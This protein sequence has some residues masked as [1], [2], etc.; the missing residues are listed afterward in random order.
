MGTAGRTFAVVVGIGALALAASCTRSPTVV[1][2]PASPG[3]RPKGGNS[4][5]PAWPEVA[6]G[7]KLTLTW[8]IYA[9]HPDPAYPDDGLR[10]RHIVELVAQVGGVAR[11]LRLPPQAGGFFE[12]DQSLCHPEMLGPG[13]VSS[14]GFYL[15]GVAG[16]FV[17]RGP[18]DTLT[19]HGFV[20]TDGLC[21]DPAGNTI[22]CPRPTKALATMR[23]PANVSIVEAIVVRD[24]AGKREP[25]ACSL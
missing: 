21:T 4:G 3:T 14:I 5:E 25:F 18:D 20:S 16:F 10:A 17:R 15:G 2:R 23:I 1:A 7:T 24:E 12:N 11:R 9:P 13:E 6:T 19:I 22:A 8:T